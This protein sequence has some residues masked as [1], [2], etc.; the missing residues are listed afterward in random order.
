MKTPI[1]IGTYRLRNGR[2]AIVRI[3]DSAIDVKIAR[4]GIP[5]AGI[6]HPMEWTAD[7]GLYGMQPGPWDLLER[8][9]DEGSAIQ[10]RL[11]YWEDSQ[12]AEWRVCNHHPAT[13]FPWQT[14][15]G[16]RGWD[17]DGKPSWKQGCSLVA[18]LRPLEDLPPALNAA[19]KAAE[20]RVRDLKKHYGAAQDVAEEARR[21]W[22]E[23]KR[24]LERL[25]KECE[26][27]K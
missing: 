14:Q 9:P 2:K 23:A 12:G 24:E 22:E 17:N 15:G 11:G 13:P 1:Q 20:D 16:T 7:D 27:G 8:L 4:G 10:M 25:E 18:F 3:I 6:E 19:V 26:V 21:M 5:D